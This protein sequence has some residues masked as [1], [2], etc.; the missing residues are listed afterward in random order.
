MR[1]IPSI[2]M[3]VALLAASAGGDVLAQDKAA[4][5]RRSIERLTETFTRLDARHEGKVTREEA[6][7]NV[8][9]TAIFNDIDINRDG[10]VTKEELDRYLTL[11][12]GGG[13]EGQ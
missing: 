6:N 11:R 10:V 1:S 3:L 13:A 12:Y 8:E 9:F 5:E 7:G 4:Y 2:V